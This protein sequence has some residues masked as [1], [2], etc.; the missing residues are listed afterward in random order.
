M[1]LP[2][3]LLP[4]DISIGVERRSR[5]PYRFRIRLRTL[6]ILVMIAALLMGGWV[7]WRREQIWK[8]HEREYLDLA[9]LY[10][11]QETRHLMAAAAGNSVPAAF[12]N[13]AGWRVI[14]MGPNEHKR[15]AAEYGRFRRRYEQA[16]SRPWQ[17]F[18]SPPAHSK[19]IG[20]QTNRVRRPQ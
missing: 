17:P 13:G 20:S 7:A 5:Q 18:G 6:L 9:G 14:R 3:P 15:L 12:T 19:S 10:A 16:A 8:Q 1:R 4:F 2:I 11:R